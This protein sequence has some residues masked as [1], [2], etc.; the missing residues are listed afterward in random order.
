MDR[1]LHSRRVWLEDAV[2]LAVVSGES[3]GAGEAPPVSDRGDGLVRG[4]AGDAVTVGVVEPDAV[5][6]VGGSG[7]PVAAE[8][9]LEGADGDEAG[10]GDVGGVMLVWA[11]SSM[12]AI[13]WHWM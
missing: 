10:G 11:F 7:V 8:G 9:E 6:V 12:N 4:T 2:G 3:A 1:R 5:Q 13:A